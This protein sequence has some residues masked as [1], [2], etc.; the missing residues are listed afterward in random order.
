MPR[1]RGKMVPYKKRYKYA[2]KAAQALAIAKR[3]K[4]LINVEIKF[5][6]TVDS[7]GVTVSKTGQIFNLTLVPEGLDL[8]QRGGSSLKTM[9]LHSRMTLTGQSAGVADK[10]RFIL[11]RAKNENGVAQ[12][13]ANYLEIVDVN[14][15]KDWDNRFHTKTLID[16]T[17]TIDNATDKIIHS[18]EW[19]EKLFG[20]VTYTGSTTTIEDGGLYLIVIGDR[21]ATLPTFKYYHRLTYTDN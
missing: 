11:F 10:V 18:L 9:W 14:S 3:I 4:R 17:I 20:H 21:V 8:N 13:I 16:K 5:F 6:D 12:T 1:R 7:T 19:H 2:D 15:P